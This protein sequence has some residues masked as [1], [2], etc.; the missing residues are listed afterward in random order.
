MQC[1][2]MATQPGCVLV[3]IAFLVLS[4]VSVVFLG[5]SGILQCL[6]QTSG[7]N[8]YLYTLHLWQIWYDR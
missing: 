3:A 8:L 6:N 2:K 7:S 4:I 5:I 1:D